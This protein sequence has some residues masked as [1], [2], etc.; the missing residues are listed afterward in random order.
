MNR[1]AIVAWL[2]AR[3]PAAPEQLAARLRGFVLRAPKER[4]AGSMTQAM[5]GLGLFALEGSLGRGETGNEVALD[6]LA[7]DA[8]VTYAFE[9]AAEEGADVPQTA[10]DLISRMV[11]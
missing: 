7:A 6:L 2:A 3:E 5:S 11:P 9:A 4:L 1:D 8:F 10:S